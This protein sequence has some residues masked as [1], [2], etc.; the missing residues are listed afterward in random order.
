MCKPINLGLFIV[1]NNKKLYLIR[2]SSQDF[3]ETMYNCHNSLELRCI[4]CQI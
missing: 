4:R 1:D 3:A 2:I